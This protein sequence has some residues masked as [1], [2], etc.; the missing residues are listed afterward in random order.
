MKMFKNKLRWYVFA[1]TAFLT[2]SLVLPEEALSR[3]GGFGGG[4]SF[5]SR[6]SSWGSRSSKK[7]AWGSQRSSRKLS[8][9]SSA[10]SMS[11][12]DKALYQK[13]S[14]KGTVFK[15]R[16]SAKR[17][18]EKN[19]GQKYSSN[20]TKKPGTRPNHIP[21]TTSVNDRKYNVGYNQSYGGYGY[22]G[23]GGGWVMYSVMRDAAMLSLLMNR[24]DYYYGQQPGMEPRRRHG[25]F[26]S[27]FWSGIFVF[28]VIFVLFSSS[29]RF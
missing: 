7:S 17:S 3:R 29:R 20:Y 27:S 18:F 12:T 23:P 26:G 14:A 11:K 28:G 5:G 15:S 9:R 22:I 24:N 6:S 10:R 2:L 8:G 13:A 25:G 21:K 4:R 19:Y 1:L 16:A